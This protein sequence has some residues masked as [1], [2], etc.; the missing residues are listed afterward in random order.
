MTARLAVAVALVAGGVF[1]L[2]QAWGIPGG[3][4]PVPLVICGAWVLLAAA[5]L[6]QTVREHGARPESGAGREPLL[7]VAVLV[8]YAI[9]L[10]PVGYLVSTA[11][12]FLLVARILGSRSLPRDAVVAVLLS[13]GVYLA[14]T[15]LLSIRLPQGVLP[16]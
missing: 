15:Q 2:V 8:G 6:A 11:V 5:H 12:A 9:L 16:L 1:L 3:S 13:A 10:D 7:I 14:F 4:R